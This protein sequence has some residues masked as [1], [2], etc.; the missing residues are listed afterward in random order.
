ML[1]QVCCSKETYIP[2][3]PSSSQQGRHFPI[4]QD[5][6]LADRSEK[7]TEIMTASATDKKQRDSP[8][9]R[10][11][12]SLKFASY[13]VVLVAV[14]ISSSSVARDWSSAK[15]TDY[16]AA[17]NPV[18]AILV[19]VFATHLGALYAE[20]TCV[21]MR[22]ISAARWL[23]RVLT[24]LLFSLYKGVIS[25]ILL[26]VRLYL[27]GHSIASYQSLLFRLMYCGNIDTAVFLGFLLDG[28][29]A[30]YGTLR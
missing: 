30:N 23:Y 3:D 17:F 19:T 21:A 10:K 26:C 29:K 16:Q 28:E 6:E 4:P 25:K 5:R 14:I 24:R 27:N 9:G 20:K 7:R 13:A 12:R 2:Y 8:F 11:A 1:E 22:E 18:F 15:R